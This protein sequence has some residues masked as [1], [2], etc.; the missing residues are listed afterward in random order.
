M[1]MEYFSSESELELGMANSGIL[2]PL[3]VAALLDAMQY[4]IVPDSGVQ[5]ASAA[6]SIYTGK[7][8][9]LEGAFVAA[10]LMKRL[11]KEY[12]PRYCILT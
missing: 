1:A 6:M 10:M 9:C 3:D 4:N 5:V 7:A 11:N 8:H 12:A 2:T